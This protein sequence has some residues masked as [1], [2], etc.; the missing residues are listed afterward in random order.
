MSN[1]LTKKQEK[2]RGKKVIDMTDDELRSW[3]NACDRMESQI[4][5]NKARRSWTQSREE[6]EDELIKRENTA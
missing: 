4:K 1:P 3:I 5:Y 6:A 2:L